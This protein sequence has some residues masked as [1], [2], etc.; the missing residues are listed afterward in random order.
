MKGLWNLDQGFLYVGEW[1]KL[2]ALR[3]NIF[4]SQRLS[5]VTSGEEKRSMIE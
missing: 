5:P 2:G 4:P 3:A 1:S